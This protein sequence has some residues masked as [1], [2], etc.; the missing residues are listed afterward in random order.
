MAKNMETGKFDPVTGST[1]T[2]FDGKYVDYVYSKEEEE[3][4]TSGKSQRRAHYNE[5]SHKK[6]DGGWPVLC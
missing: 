3:E 5:A 4:I 1:D 2:Y 6:T